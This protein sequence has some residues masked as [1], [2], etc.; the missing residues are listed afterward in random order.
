MLIYF[1]QKL[2][3]KDHKPKHIVTKL[4]KLLLNNTSFDSVQRLLDQGANP[5]FLGPDDRSPLHQAVWNDNLALAEL[6]LRYGAD[7][8][9]KNKRHGWSPL[10]LVYSPQMVDLLVFHGADLMAM[11]K[12]KMMTDDFNSQAAKPIKF[13]KDSTGKYVLDS[14]GHKQIQNPNSLHAKLY[15]THL[16]NQLPDKI[17]FGH[18]WYLKEENLDLDTLPSPKAPDKSAKYRT[19]HIHALTDNED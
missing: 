14:L 12:Q 13:M 18:P 4:D 7:V 5:N 19:R 17:R 11:D 10:H 2:D 6:L 3:L 15:I 1:F 16:K 9:L 8:N